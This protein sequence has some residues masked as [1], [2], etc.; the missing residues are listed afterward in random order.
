M[1]QSLHFLL[2]TER[3]WKVAGKIW[4]KKTEEVFILKKKDEKNNKIKIYE[5]SMQRTMSKALLQII[6]FWHTHTNN[7]DEAKHVHVFT[8]EV[9]CGA[10]QIQWCSCERHAPFCEDD[11]H[12]NVKVYSVFNI[13]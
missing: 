11:L 3:V 13:M 6:L 7:N 10:S 2:L 1:V 4:H 9:S 5:A 12:K 8:V